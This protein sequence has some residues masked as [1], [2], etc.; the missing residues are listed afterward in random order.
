M[1]IYTRL[2]QHS[3]CGEII[4]KKLILAKVKG[5]HSQGKTQGPMIWHGGRYC[6]PNQWTPLWEHLKVTPSLKHACWG[7]WSILALPDDAIKVMFART[8]LD[9]GV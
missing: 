9:D 4:L 5:G 2:R 7:M 1:G 3:R 6:V 8:P